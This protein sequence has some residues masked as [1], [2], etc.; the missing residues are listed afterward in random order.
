M[1]YFNEIQQI[2]CNGEGRLPA[3]LQGK[4]RKR[5]IVFCRQVIMYFLRQFSDKDSVSL[6]MIG[7]VFNKD[8]ATVLHSCKTI[9][10]LIDTD[11]NIALKI[12]LYEAD[13]KTIVNFNTN[14]QIDKLLEIKEYLRMKIDNELPINFKETMLYNKLIKTALKA[15]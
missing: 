12:K 5:E 14:V 7:R 11:K 9:K 4:T 2:V 8:H 1:K 15:N 10:N 13:I 6:A 3:A